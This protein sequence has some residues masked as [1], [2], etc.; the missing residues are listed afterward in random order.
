MLHLLEWRIL[1]S[2]C[3]RQVWWR[4]Q[5]QQRRIESKPTRQTGGT[6][7]EYQPSSK[8][9]FHKGSI[10]RGRRPGTIPKRWPRGGAPGPLLSL[11]PYPCLP[12]LLLLSHPPGP[13]TLSCCQICILK[14]FVWTSGKR[15]HTSY[16]WSWQPSLISLSHPFTASTSFLITEFAACGSLWQWELV[17]MATGWWREEQLQ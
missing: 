4:R 11:M 13:C 9:A 10:T 3:K 7:T 14:Q 5:K 2:T 16:L 1:F 8:Q 17:V 15:K 6:E 12:A